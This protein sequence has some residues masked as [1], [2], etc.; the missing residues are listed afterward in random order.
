[1]FVKKVTVALGTCAAVAASMFGAF[2]LAGPAGAK[3]KCVIVP[4]SSL[5]PYLLS[6]CDGAT[7]PANATVTFR[8]HD[9]NS[10]AAHYPPY[11]NLATRR[12]VKHGVLKPIING[13]GIFHELKRVK[14][15]H[16]TWTYTSI[17][18]S[19]PSWFDNHK[20]T[21]YLQIQQ[22]DSRASAGT[23]YGPITTVHV[24]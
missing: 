5:V 23:Y 22:I 18:E 6:P 12:V 15:S 21:Y 20:G 24:G 19:F 16:G 13:N 17:R 2:A 4:G 10:Q 9:G 1:L 14:G 7:V 11:L 8:V 3:Q